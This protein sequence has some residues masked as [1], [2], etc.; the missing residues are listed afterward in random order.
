MKIFSGKNKNIS[1]KKVYIGLKFQTQTQYC[2]KGSLKKELYKLNHSD[3]RPD[4]WSQR[5][6]NVI[7][8]KSFD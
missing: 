2:I 1:V 7:L 8:H 4:C 5:V 6:L 3:G